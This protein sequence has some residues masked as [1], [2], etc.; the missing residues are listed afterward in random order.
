MPW[1]ER[2]RHCRRCAAASASDPGTWSLLAGLRRQ[3]AL[4]RIGALAPR[5]HG[6]PTNRSQRTTLPVDGP[7]IVQRCQQDAVDAAVLV[8]NCPVCH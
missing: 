7:E 4:G 6:R 5:F 1:I 3:A 8:P 2:D